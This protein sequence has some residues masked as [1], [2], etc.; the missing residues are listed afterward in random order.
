MRFSYELKSNNSLTLGIELS[1]GL[2]LTGH[3]NFKLM[4]D[5][6]RL[7]EVSTKIKNHVFSHTRKIM[8]QNKNYLNL[9]VNRFVVNRNQNIIPTYLRTKKPR[10]ST[11]K[12]NLKSISMENLR[13]NYC[14]SNAEANCDYFV[15]WHTT[16][17]SD[18]C[19]KRMPTLN[20]NRSSCIVT[21][22]LHRSHRNVDGTNEITRTFVNLH[23]NG[24][25][26]EISSSHN[27]QMT[28]DQ[29]FCARNKHKP[30]NGHP[31]AKKFGSTSKFQSR[32]TD[33]D[34]LPV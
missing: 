19:Y 2:S 6:F 24:N 28:H 32:F 33:I 8:C 26:L 30:S 29:Q 5:F 20:M 18:P 4:N 22:S 15:S 27:L 12:N 7:I 1:F 10:R 13:K 23:R 31:K 14:T 3:V 25:H 11:I 16:E 9:N 21:N 34:R 17:R